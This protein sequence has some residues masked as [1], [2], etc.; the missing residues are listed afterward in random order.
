L[1]IVVLTS[2]NA[3]SSIFHGPLY[4]NYLYREVDI[5]IG[6]DCTEP[7]SASDISMSESGT[8]RPS[9]SDISVSDPSDT[10]APRRTAVIG[11][12]RTAV[13]GV[14]LSSSA[15]VS[16]VLIVHSHFL[17]FSL[18]LRLRLGSI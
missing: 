12:L 6:S 14:M 2:T 5:L 17:F 10:D 16:V 13:R 3:L 7:S 1:I 15:F 8:N 11:V 4:L 9:A 18:L